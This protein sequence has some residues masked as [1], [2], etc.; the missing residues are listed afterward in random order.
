MKESQVGR[1]GPVQSWTLGR[2][3]FQLE[4]EVEGYILARSVG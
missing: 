2:M 1:I 4:P 3:A